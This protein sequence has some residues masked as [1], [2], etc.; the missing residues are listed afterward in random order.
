MHEGGEKDTRASYCALVISSLTNI[1]TPQLIYNASDFLVSCQSYEGGIGALPEAEA[2]GGYTFCG[3]SALYILGE[4]HRLDLNSLLS[5]VVQR[6]SSSEGGFQGRTNKL[7]DG[8]Y[9]WW[10]AGIFPLLDE[11]YINPQMYSNDSDNVPLDCWPEEEGSWIYDQKFLQKFILCCC[12]NPSGG[13][14]D[15]P[16]VVPDYYHS[17]YVLSGFSASQHN[18]F[19]STLLTTNLDDISSDT[20]K[21]NLVASTH[22]V[23]NIPFNKVFSIKKHFS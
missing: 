23:Y 13:L 19:Y 10:Q 2:H 11:I 9:S 4:T 18:A 12:Q 15:K 8:C 16:S 21:N 20:I 14:R 7:V 17:C 1:M 6:Q 3:L 22:P 5:W